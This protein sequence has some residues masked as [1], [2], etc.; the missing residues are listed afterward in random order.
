MIPLFIGFTAA[1]M[2]G[3]LTAALLGYAQSAS[4]PA[5][6]Y[7]PLAGALATLLCVAV[8][9]V[10]FTYFIAT[11]KWVQ[12]AVSVKHLDPSLVAPTRSF[13][14]QALPAAL[15]AMTTV[16]LTA[17]IGAATYNYG[18]RPLWH[19]ALAWIALAMNVLAALLEYRAVR[20]NGSLID[21]ILA[22]I[23]SLDLKSTP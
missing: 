12:H 4:H 5:S 6:Y 14:A 13:K 9:C 22:R 16:F 18:L 17:V 20:R 11:A 3:L 15:L 2:L 10:V 21:Q 19:H 8:H 1:N 23:A 7:H